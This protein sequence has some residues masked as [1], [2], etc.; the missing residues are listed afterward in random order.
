[1]VFNDSIFSNIKYG[2]ITASDEKV[3]EAAKMAQIHDRIMEWPKGYQ[4]VV[5]ERGVK[6]SGGEKQRGEHQSFD[7]LRYITLTT[8]TLVNIARTVLKSPKILLL[9]EATSALDSNTEKAIQGQLRRLVGSLII[10]DK[11]RTFNNAA[12]SVQT[13][14]KTTIAIA[15]RLSTIVN[16]DKIIVLDKGKLVETG[17]HDELLKV[18]GG[19][20]RK[21]WETQTS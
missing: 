21:L 5:G 4:T 3:T 10:R 7:C 14:G 19:F 15:H 17:T 2:D 12:L 8:C 11:P 1:M 16:A 13:Q 18:T 20:Y 9:D 6:L